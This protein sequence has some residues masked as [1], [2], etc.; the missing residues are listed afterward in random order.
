MTPEHLHVAL[1]HF[2]IVG[3]MLALPVAVFGFWRQ[4][5]TILTIGL[6]LAAVA[7][8]TTPFLMGTGEAAV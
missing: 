6:A 5:R 7:C 8:W 4:D 1:V 3:L 2:P